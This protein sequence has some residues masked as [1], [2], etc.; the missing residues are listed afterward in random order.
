MNNK[1]ILIT[2][3]TGHLG[4]FLI[5]RWYNDN[6][7]IV[8]SRDEAKQY[9]LKK[10]Y[11]KINCVIGDI[12]DYDSMR[13][14]ANLYKPNIGIFAASMK[15]I[16]AVD[17]NPEQAVRTIIH[18]AINSRRISEECGFEAGCFI[19]TDKSRAATTL[20]GSMKFVAGEIFI[21]NSDILDVRLSSVIY[22]NILNSTGSIIPLIWHAIKN[23]YKLKLYG[24]DMTRFILPTSKAIDVIEYALL[25]KGYNIIPDIKS[26]K[27]I[28]L[29]KIYEQFGLQW[30][31]GE[32][33]ISEKI[34]ECV[35]T[36]EELP[37]T[38]YDCVDG[39]FKMHYKNILP[40]GNNN[41]LYDERTESFIEYT[42]GK[43]NFLMS[44]DE[45]DQLLKS[46][47][48]FKP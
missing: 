33:R 24:K 34:H 45:L 22:G 39:M 41:P 1:T 42:S 13:R 48:Y 8:Y 2:G 9:L 7:I 35:I 36:T 28:E 31:Y 5:D 12:A 3:G 46:N 43:S 26:I 20:Y 30:E 17:E 15:Q 23:N 19:S 37:R 11:P 25:T 27:V 44:I 40:P 6:N 47:N 10:K 32:P 29:F 14:M 4:K 21:V 18:G 38:T 16:E